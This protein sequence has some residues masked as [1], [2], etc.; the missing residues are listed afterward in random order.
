MTVDEILV[1]LEMIEAVLI[2]R[3]RQVDRGA[4]LVAAL[5]AADAS[6]AGRVAVP[7]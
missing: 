4:A 6:R 2:E 5:R 1:A 3:G 7:A